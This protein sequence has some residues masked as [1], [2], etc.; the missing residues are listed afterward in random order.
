MPTST[1]SSDLG[2]AGYWYGRPASLRPRARSVEW[3][4]IARDLLAKA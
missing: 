1:A 4:E 2:S 3:T